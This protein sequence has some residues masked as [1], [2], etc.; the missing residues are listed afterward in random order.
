VAHSDAVKNGSQ[1]VEP[2]CFQLQDK[3]QKAFN[4]DPAQT[5]MFVVK[6]ASNDHR[7]FKTCRESTIPSGRDAQA[8]EQLNCYLLSRFSRPFNGVFFFA[9]GSKEVR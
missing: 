5:Q 8:K 1:S 3:K 4:I 7:K 6:Q 2:S 9:R